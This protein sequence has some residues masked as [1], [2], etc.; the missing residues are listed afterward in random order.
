ML[1]TLR[2]RVRTERL[3]DL[4]PVK[5]PHIISVFG[6]LLAVVSGY[7]FSNARWIE[8][9]IFL[10]L[11]SFMDVLDGAVARK[12]KRE[13]PAGALL[14]AVLDRLSEGA[15]LLGIAMGTLLWQLCMIA[16]LL[17]LM[18]SYVKARAEME[19]KVGN[20][21]W[22]DLME[23]GERMLLLSIVFPIAALQG[24]TLE[25]LL[26]FNVLLLIGFLQ[27][28]KRAVVVLGGLR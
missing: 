14:D 22:P 12:W 8:G 4:V 10:L 5:N 3:A 18:I 13:S 26:V 2:K 7:Y 15:V 9:G 6:F 1:S 28:F 24:Y 25:F 16:L 27:R 21:K 19:K 11:S 20:Y 17:S 23:R